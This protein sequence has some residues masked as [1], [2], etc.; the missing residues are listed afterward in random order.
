VR[1]KD[2][3]ELLLAKCEGLR[4]EKHNLLSR[5]KVRRWSTVALWEDGNRYI[6]CV[7]LQNMHCPLTGACPLFAV[8]SK[9]DVAMN[10]CLV[11]PTFFL[12][13]SSLLEPWM[14]SKIRHFH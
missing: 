7:S 13:R 3:D 2:F 10:C 6:V 11:Y 14:F 8:V 9:S 1:H 5:L 12:N 4:H